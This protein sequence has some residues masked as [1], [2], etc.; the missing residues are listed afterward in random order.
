MKKQVE[1]FRLIWQSKRDE[2]KQWLFYNVFIGLLPI[3]LSWLPLLVLWNWK[4]VWDPLLNGSVMVFG[5]CLT[6]ASLSFFAEEAKRELKQTNRFIWNWLF[7][8][9]LVSTGAYI[10]VV[11]L[12]TVAPASAQ[13]KIIILLSLTLLLLAVALNLQL[14]AIRLA[15][16]DSA[17]FTELLSRELK[18]L[19]KSAAATKEVDGI[20]L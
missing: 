16:S 14:A 12:N 9:L 8:L 6:A 20:K 2:L 19:S 3:W 18:T 11:T 17:L 7:I 4:S 1:I 10:T 5:G 15:Y 13:G